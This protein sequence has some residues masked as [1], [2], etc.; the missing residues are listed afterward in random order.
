MMLGILCDCDRVCADLTHTGYHYRMRESSSMHSYGSSYVT[1][2]MVY[3]QR[4]RALYDEK[5]LSGDPRLEE[6]Y[7]CFCFYNALGSL[8]AVDFDMEGLKKQSPQTSEWIQETIRSLSRGDRRMLSTRDAI[9]LWLLSKGMY[10]P[11]RA[12]YRINHFLRY[13]LKAR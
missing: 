3:A 1:H 13:T 11:V 9:V 5:G 6:N 8:Y 7:V 10:G 12:M 4:L 2:R